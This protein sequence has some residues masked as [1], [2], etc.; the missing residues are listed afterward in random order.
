MVDMKPAHAITFVGIL[1]L[2]ACAIAPPTGPNVVVMPA[3]G[4]SF[5]EFQQ[6]DTT[7]RQFASQQI[8]NGSPAQASAN[9]A[10]S[11]AA[12]G[13]L[14][15][16]A[17]GAALGA[18]AGNPALGAAA[19]AGGGLLVGSAAGS[20]AAA[21]SGA[22]LQQ[23]YDVSYV[24]CMS[25]KG[26]SVPT[27]QAAPTAAYAYPY[28]ADPYGAYPY[29]YPAYSGYYYPPPAVGSVFIGGRYRGRW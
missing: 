18:A 17:A 27:A 16:A 1:S 20:N 19:G 25:A 6:D 3:Q 13:T 11:S 22:S 15:G 8:G 12:V 5:A 4:K 10:I 28:P 23:R 24:Q 14:I 21:V 2:S 26:E 29:P 7:C 9:S